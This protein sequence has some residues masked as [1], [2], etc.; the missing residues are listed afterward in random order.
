[1]RFKI[2]RAESQRREKRL[3]ELMRDHRLSVHDVTRLVGHKHPSMVYMWT[4][5]P[6]TRPVPRYVIELLELKLEREIKQAA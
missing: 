4:A 6:P 1:M 2:G 3:R 5:R